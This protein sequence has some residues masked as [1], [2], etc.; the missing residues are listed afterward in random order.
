MP[1]IAILASDGTRSRFAVDKPRVTIGRSRESDVFLPDQ[2]LSR[3]HAEIRVVRGAC[4]LVDLGS[5]NGTLLNGARVDSERALRHGDVI[6]LGEHVLTFLEHDGEDEGDDFEPAGTRVFAASDL[7]DVALRAPVPAEDAESLARRNRMLGILTRSAS[8]LIEHRPLHELFETV[9]DLLFDALPVERGVILL[10]EGAPARPHVKASRSRRGETIGRVPGSITRRVVSE[11]VALLLPN[12]LDDA[13]FRTQDSILAT[14]IRSALCAP[15]LYRTAAD[16]SSPAHEEV[17]GLVY[18]DT[19]QRSHPFADEDIQLLTAL[20]NIAA[21]KI[22]NVRLLEESLEKRAM[23]RDLR[24]AA[25]IQNGLLPRQAP[26]VP[27]YGLSGI[28][29]PCRT[30]GGDY[31]DF[32]LEGERLLLAL[33]DVS[34]KGTGAALLMTMLRA[35]VRGHWADG[36]AADAMARINRTV[37][38]NIPD[39]KY[40]TFFMARLDPASG[41]LCYVNAGHNP[42]LLVRAGGSVELLDRGGVVLGLLEP[43]VYDEGHVELRPGDA[44]VVYSDGVTET[45]NADDEEFG[46][47]G[48]LAVVTRHVGRDAPSLQDAVLAAL[49]AHAPGAKATDDR[50]LIVLKRH[51]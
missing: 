48:L 31:F 28:N 37:F 4:S 39:G 24:V 40:I 46:E 8:A 50:T 32:T 1:E 27:G 33:G 36:G 16:A 43:V 42:P 45:W 19:L 47:E 11:R 25:E 15:L 18:L 22:E 44:L 21:A 51:A 30:I 29:R 20:A 23:E 13:A 34:G 2:W 38:Q 35:A 14:G 26:R 10:L 6:T 3:H 5:K 12:L 41:R 9:L 7:S 49:E 17:I